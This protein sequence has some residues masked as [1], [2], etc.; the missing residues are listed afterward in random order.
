MNR[1]TFPIAAISFFALCMIGMV[2]SWTDSQPA[3]A[4]TTA[5]TTQPLATLT[6]RVTDLRNHNG[7][8]LFGV[9]NSAD[10]FPKEK[11]KSVNWQVKPIDSDSVV[12]TVSLPPGKYAAS[13]LHD[14]NKNNKMDMNFLGVPKEGYGVTNNPKP[15]YREAR[16]DEA[17]FNLPVGGATL[18]ISIQYF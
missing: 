4:A 8:V 14:E 10:G 5:P 6:I 1:S 17:V 15:D 13:A 3:I 2:G 11:S 18:T 12:F 16:F 9:F 7:Q